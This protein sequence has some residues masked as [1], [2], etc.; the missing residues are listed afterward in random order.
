MRLGGRS[1]KFLVFA[2]P[3]L[4]DRAA[5]FRPHITKYN[6]KCRMEKCKT[7]AVTGVWSSGNVLCGVM[8]H[9]SLFGSLMGESG[10]DNGNGNEA[11]FQGLVEAPYFQ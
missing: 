5:A 10:Y 8:D 9:T 3:S 6:A 7:H 2:I 4:H 1:R 11:V